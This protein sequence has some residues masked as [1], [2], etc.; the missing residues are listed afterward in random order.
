MNEH[1]SA[2]AIAKLLAGTEPSAPHQMH[3]ADCDVCRAQVDEARSAGAD[4]T[5]RVFPR[6]LPVVTRRRPAWAGWRLPA[7]TGWFIRTI[8]LPAAAAVA[9]AIFLFAIRKPEEELRAPPGVLEVQA[10]G[11]HSL[12]VYAQRDG[13]VFRVANGDAMYPGDAIRF[14][15]HPDGKRWILVVS[16]DGTG[17]TTV[18]H[19]FGGSASTPL[20]P[21]KRIEIDG[22]IILDDALG[23]ERIFAVF[24]DRPVEAADITRTLSDLVKM[25][26]DGP[27]E[28]RAHMNGL[29]AADWGT[30]T[31][32]IEKRSR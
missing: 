7:S 20:P 19:P 12:D 23:P 9:T 2:L 31:I 26:A 32:L 29:H 5:S 25:S 28:V 16:V 17:A 8:F 10:R 22:S 1:L 3:L 14:V 30:A 6:T 4:F 18:Y 21:G 27:D 15:V 11:A 24:S 13:R